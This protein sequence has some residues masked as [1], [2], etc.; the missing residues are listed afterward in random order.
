MFVKYGG[1]PVINPEGAKFP[2]Q[3]FFEGRP[4]AIEHNFKSDEKPRYLNMTSPKPGSYFAAIF[5]SY[6]D[7]NNEEIKQE[8]LSAECF[9]YVEF[10]LYTDKPKPPEIITNGQLVEVEIHGDPLCY[11][12]YI[13]NDISSVDLYI[14]HIRFCFGCDSITVRI[15]KNNLPTKNS[16]LAEFTVENDDWEVVKYLKVTE[17]NWYYVCYQLEPHDQ[18]FFMYF[19]FFVKYASKTIGEKSGNLSKPETDNRIVKM[20][21]IGKRRLILLENDKNSTVNVTG[22]TAVTG[23]VT[24]FENVTGRDPE[25]TENVTDVTNSTENVLKTTGSAA[26]VPKNIGSASNSTKNA[27]SALEI[28]KLKRFS[29][30]NLFKL[31]ATYREY[32]L[33]REASSEAFKFSFEF[34]NWQEGEPIYPLNITNDEFAAL[35]FKLN[36]V[37]DSGG[38]VQFI[39]AFKPKI[40]KTPFGRRLER[41]NTNHTVVFCVKNKEILIPT[42]EQRCVSNKIDE[43]PAFILNKTNTNSSI[44]IPYPEGGHWYITARL[45]CSGTCEKCNGCS[46]ECKLDF[47]TCRE[48]CEVNNQGNCSETCLKQIIAV[49][50]CGKAC[51]CTG[52]CLAKSGSCN[53]SVIFDISS[54]A[55]ISNSCGPNGRCTF[56]VADG[57]VY[58]SCMCKNNYR[59][60]DCSDDSLANSYLTIVIE[61]LLLVLSN[62]AF[63]PA[64]Y[65]AYKRKYYVEST[66]YFCTCFFSTFYHAC[67]AGENIISFCIA[68]LNVLQFSDFYVALLGLW[69]TM[70]AMAHVPDP[71]K[72]LL[73]MLGA[74][75]LSFGTTLN[76]TSLW[77]I[78]IPGVVGFL[79]ISSSWAVKYYRTKKIFPSK[80]YL[81]RFLP[82]GIFVV[83]IGIVCYSF[84]QTKNNY[85][86]LHS[87]WHVLMATGILIL[88]PN[89]KYFSPKADS[90]RI[91]NG[92]C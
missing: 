18:D 20:Q 66:V 61:L 23:N 17:H 8:G 36:D 92:D 15:Q 55:C 58:T 62:L 39:A 1:P 64:V 68:K 4:N 28:S 91:T 22:L 77:V 2:K 41:A 79:M 75:L 25:S 90:S 56:M 37:V 72:S 11:K 35:K 21:E 57:F 6:K 71:F 63:L 50:K 32:S 49:E 16:S 9:S 51:D 52:D 48:N 73:H 30:Q 88:L 29:D 24:R 86:Y 81:V 13:D 54:S 42:V 10:V 26:N 80:H 70:V 34:S 85:K 38:T 7:P 43:K 53:E 19:A 27:T 65:I 5:N 31:P 82:L 40:V 60:W 76:K 67:D 45:F 83:A 84:L 59:G 33:M 12:F 46:E 47:M 78:L 89:E 87:L 44:M 14:K 3:F 74:I 69:V